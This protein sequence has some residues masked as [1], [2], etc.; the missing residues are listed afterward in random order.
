[1][2]VTTPTGWVTAL[3]L[4]IGAAV[5]SLAAGKGA[6]YI[7]NRHGQRIDIVGMTNTSQLCR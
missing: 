6:K 3:A 4:G 2:F 7:Y 5:G 1:L